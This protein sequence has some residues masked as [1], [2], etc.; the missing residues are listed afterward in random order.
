MTFSG[1]R[2]TQVISFVPDPEP[3]LESTMSRFL[4]PLGFT[5]ACAWVFTLFVLA[6]R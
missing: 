1:L 5:L 6:S 4:A 3:P 2:P